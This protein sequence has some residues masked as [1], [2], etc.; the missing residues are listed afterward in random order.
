TCVVSGSTNPDIIKR[1]K[2]ARILVDKPKLRAR[3]ERACTVSS[4]ETVVTIEEERVT[5]VLTKLAQ[6][7]ALYELHE[8]C[9]G[10]PVQVSFKPLME[11]SN[12][13]LNEFEA[14]AISS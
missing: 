8:P 7:H 14:P 6:G 10:R 13:E 2:I 4:R 1:E 5:T 3:I 12:L 11:M 9:P